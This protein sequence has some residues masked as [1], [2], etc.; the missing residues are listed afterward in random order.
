MS[1]Q[2]GDTRIELMFRLEAALKRIE[3]LE[4]LEADLKVCADRLEEN[5]ATMDSAR[6]RIEQ[7]E[8]ALR[9]IKDQLLT[10]D[11]A[12]AIARAALTPKRE[13]NSDVFKGFRGNND[14]A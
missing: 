11:Q 14:N 2:G 7:L 1:D 6:A 8:A 3:Q 12:S 9:E 13:E 10:S 5:T 4:A